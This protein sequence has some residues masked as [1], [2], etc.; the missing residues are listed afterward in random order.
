MMFNY[1]DAFS[2]NIGWVTEAEQQQLRSAC[3][4]IAGAGGVGSAHAL[5]LARLGIGAFQLADFDKFDVH[6]FNRQAGAFMS[7][8]GEPKVEVMGRMVNDIN[9]EADVRLFT[10]G[11]NKDNVATFL[12]G[13]DLYVDSL[14]FFALE[15]RKLIFSECEKR[16]IPAV[17]AAPLG[18]GSAFLAFIPGQGMTFEEY[19]RL[20]G[21]SENDQLVRFLVGVAPT[22]WQRHYLVDPTRADFQGKKGPSTAMAVDFC[23]GVAATNVLKIILK[24]GRVITAP[25]GIHYDAYLNRTKITW[26]PWGNLNPIQQLAFRV[27]KSIVLGK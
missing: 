1:E 15:A 22:M 2:R 20:D 7:T 9:P 27:A 5:T 6:N 4:A 8:V 10:E 13:V 18:M 25:R 24:R 11:V 21:L 14:D 12:E 23:A 19:F 17:T 3:I 16:M 26:R